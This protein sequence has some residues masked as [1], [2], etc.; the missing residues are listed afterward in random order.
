MDDRNRPSGF[1]IAIAWPELYCKQSLSWYDWPASLLGISKSN[2]YRAGH[3]ALVLIKKDTPKCHYFDFGRYHSPVHHGRVRSA[4]SDHDLE[5]KTVPEISE[6]GTVLK[7]FKEIM[8]ELQRNTSCHGAGALY[9]SYGGIDFNRS[10]EMA[11][12]LQK[13]AILYGPFKAGRNN[14][15]RFV[16]KVIL[17]GRPG[18][19][20]SLRL[21]F[22]VPLTPTPMNN[23]NSMGKRI[24]IPHITPYIP[25][26]IRDKHT[27]QYLRSTLGPPVRYEGIPAGAQWLAGEGAGSWFTFAVENRDITVTRY[28]PE[29][30]IECQGLYY[31]TGTDNP[32]DILYA[33][34]TYPSDCRLITMVIGTKRISLNLSKKLN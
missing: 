24:T 20:K 16:N 1:V 27:K 5:V 29:G 18:I 11:V 22:M 33:T 34:I 28:S 13:S 7:N 23:V 31:A 9:A 12:F 10:Y 6:D 15:S 30:L 25:L 19:M 26:I 14:C 4:L 8:E 17:A 2:Y 21:R 3:A 32:V